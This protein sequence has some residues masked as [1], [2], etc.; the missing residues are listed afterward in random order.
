VGRS[1]TLR[2]LHLAPPAALGIAAPVQLRG[3][4]GRDEIGR[5]FSAADV[6]VRAAVMEAA[7]NVILEG[8]AAGC[9]VVCANS[10]GPVEYLTDHQTVSSSNR[11]TRKPW[12]SAYAPPHFAGDEVPDGARG[13]SA[14]RT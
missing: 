13:S 3:T 14:C 7:G 11:E 8:L 12:P 2:V 10:H 1:S 9:P 4:V 6:F 5:Y